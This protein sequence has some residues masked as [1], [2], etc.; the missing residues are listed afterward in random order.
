MLWRF[1][2]IFSIYILFPNSRKKPYLHFNL[3]CDAIS[4]NSFYPFFPLPCYDYENKS[5]KHGHFNLVRLYCSMLSRWGT[6]MGEVDSRKEI[7]SKWDNI[8]KGNWGPC[9]RTLSECDHEYLLLRFPRM[10]RG[11]CAWCENHQRWQLMIKSRFCKITI[12]NSFPLANFAPYSAAAPNPR[13]CCGYG[14][15]I[16]FLLRSSVLGAWE[17]GWGSIGY[18]GLR[19]GYRSGGTILRAK[20]APRNGNACSGARPRDGIKRIAVAKLVA[21]ACSFAGA[22][23]R[24]LF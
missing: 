3:F 21:L 20:I 23:R 19:R 11:S 13:R 1:L 4:Q 6:P 8:M 17:R 7:A 5:N 15:E 22:L 24:T 10:C 12:E 18:I 14:V 2:L 9:D 16:S